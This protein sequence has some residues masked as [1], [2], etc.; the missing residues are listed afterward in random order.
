MPQLDHKGP[1]LKGPGTGRKL[2]LCSN[3]EDS[4]YVLGQG[5]GL[6][7]KSPEGKGLGKRLQSTNIF[8]YKLK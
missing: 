3:Q 2:G 5:M 8:N 7:R 6:K 4:H 1:E